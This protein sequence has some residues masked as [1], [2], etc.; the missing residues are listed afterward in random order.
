MKIYSSKDPFDVKNY[1]GKDLWVECQG[2]DGFYQYFRF[3]S[4]HG[5]IVT[6]NVIYADIIDELDPECLWNDFPSY[7]VKPID[8][9]RYFTSEVEYYLYDIK[10]YADLEIRTTA[11]IKECLQEV[12]DKLTGGGH[13]A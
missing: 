10:V 2:D 7:P 3:L 5:N 1:I 8:L 11:E 6:C 12:K 9:N 4:L 13:G